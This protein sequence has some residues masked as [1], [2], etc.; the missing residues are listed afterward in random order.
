MH[1]TDRSYSIKDSKEK[2]LHSFRVSN[3][4]T[5]TFKVN[6][7]ECTYSLASSGSRDITNWFSAL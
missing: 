7:W 2:R 6:S 5:T 3:C 1:K 4:N